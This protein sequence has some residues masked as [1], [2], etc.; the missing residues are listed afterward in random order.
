MDISDSHIVTQIKQGDIETY[1]NMEFAVILD[2]AVVTAS[3]H[4]IN[5]LKSKEECYL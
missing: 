4:L 2:D 1:S 3:V 5:N